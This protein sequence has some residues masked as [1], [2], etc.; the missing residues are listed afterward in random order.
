LERILGDDIS[1][2]KEWAAVTQGISPEAGSEDSILRAVIRQDAKA[3]EAAM[4]LPFETEPASYTRTLEK[5]ADEVTP[6]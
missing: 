4:A 2:L 5:I 1:Y 3:R 6:K